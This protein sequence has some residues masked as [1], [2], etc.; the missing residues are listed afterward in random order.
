MAIPGDAITVPLETWDE[1]LTSA[2]AERYLSEGNVR[3]EKA[4]SDGQDR[5]VV[6]AELSGPPG[7][8]MS[9]PARTAAGNPEARA[10]PIRLTVAF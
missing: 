6:A 2:L 3:G 1:R 8:I 9:R 4:K 5:R 10:C 7:G